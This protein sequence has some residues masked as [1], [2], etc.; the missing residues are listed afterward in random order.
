MREYKRSEV[1]HALSLCMHMAES[2]KESS[3]YPQ[4][5]WTTK[6]REEIYWHVRE[7][8]FLTAREHG[9]RMPEVLFAVRES[10]MGGRE[11]VLK[12]PPFWDQVV[13]PLVLIQEVMEQ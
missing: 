9:I 12:N 5:N 10:R 3:E 1:I 2:I 8:V 13:H 4:A 6:T 11:V 7:R